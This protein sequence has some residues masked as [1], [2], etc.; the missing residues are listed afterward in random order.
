MSNDRNNDNFGNSHESQQHN[1]NSWNDESRDAQGINPDENSEE[2]N[3]SDNDDFNNQGWPEDEE[4]NAKSRTFKED[5]ESYENEQRTSTN[6]TPNNNWD[7]NDP[8]QR[9][10]HIHDD[11]QL[12]A[13]SHSSFSDDEQNR[14][15]QENDTRNREELE[16]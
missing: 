14:Y 7:A 4:K 5:E 8:I 9:T 1:G 15:S 13:A 10:T 6:G 2:L 11:E 16:E 12:D 3:A